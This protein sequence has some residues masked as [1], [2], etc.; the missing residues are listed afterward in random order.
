[1]N[2]VPPSLILLWNPLS[3]KAFKVLNVHAYGVLARLRPFVS[4]ARWR[5]TSWS[6]FYDN[7]PERLRSGLCLACGGTGRK[8]PTPARL[9]KGT[10]EP[11]GEIWAT[12]RFL[13]YFCHY[14]LSYSY[15]GFISLA[16]HLRDTHSSKK[17]LKNVQYSGVINCVNKA[18]PLEIMSVLVSFSCF[19]IRTSPPPP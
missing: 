3:R 16:G 10:N 15:I 17:S 5:R 2:S 4:G 8:V 19:I 13:L 7:S 14:T 11:T 12:G 1:M 18:P 9:T 6:V